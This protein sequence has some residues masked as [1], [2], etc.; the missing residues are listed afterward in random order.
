MTKGAPSE[1][2]TTY[3]CTLLSEAARIPCLL[4]FPYLL[5]IPLRSLLGSLGS[6]IQWPRRRECTAALCTREN[7]DRCAWQWFQCY[8]SPDRRM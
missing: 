1:S 3:P 2:S 8:I 4:N 6:P 7:S 5:E